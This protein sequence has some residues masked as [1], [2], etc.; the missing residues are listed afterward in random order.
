MSKERLLSLDVFRGIT[1]A[2][3]ILVNDPGSWSHV[4]APLL[5][6]KWH[7]LTPTDL[8][9]PFFVFMMGVALSLGR[10]KEGA[11]RK[12]AL[13]KALKRAL[14]LFLIGVFLNGFPYFDLVNIRIPGVLQRIAL[15]F[16]AIFWMHHYLDVKKQY[17][18]GATI[19][20]T[21]WV[22]M[23][24][25]PV[26][27]VGPANLDP[28]TN[29]AAWMDS[30]LLKGHM[31][32]ATKTWDPEG[33]LSTF[34]AVVTGAMGMWTGRYLLKHDDKNHALVRVLIYGNLSVLIALMWN[35][36]L[37]INKSLWTSS[38]VLAT[39]GLGMLSFGALYWLL[40]V[41]K[42][43]GKW[44]FP[45]KVFGMNAITVYVFAGILADLMGIIEFS[46]NTLKGHIYQGIATLIPEPKM[47][48]LIFAIMFVSICYIPIYVMYKRGIF[49][50][51]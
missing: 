25:V 45:F 4:Y 28:G 27:G 32:S 14:M 47:A 34:P 16:A 18:L 33:F 40:D 37:P 46:N 8:V 24:I 21:Y 10:P 48:S 12:S 49:W 31:W 17:Y 51:V 30:I 22:I 50:K 44:T 7:G 6:A 26:P 39:G 38:F 29:F 41:L 35:P 2:G 11:D 36:F 43:R 3:M 23:V 9:F 1:I 15:V 13:Q 42:K 19:L 20:V 5:H